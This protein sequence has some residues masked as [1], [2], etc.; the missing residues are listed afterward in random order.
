MNTATRGGKWSQDSVL[1][2]L[3]IAALLCGPGVIYLFF[4]GQPLDIL[5]LA[6]WLPLTLLQ[7][8]FFVLSDSALASIAAAGSL[9]CLGTFA[10]VRRW[11]VVLAT[12]IYVELQ[13]VLLG[14]TGC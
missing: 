3:T 5:R 1:G 14:L 9:T 10:L 2:F 12:M 13:M 11:W 4:S 7:N 6:H 8:H